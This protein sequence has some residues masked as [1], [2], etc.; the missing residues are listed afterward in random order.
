MKNKNL[1]ALVLAGVLLFSVF[2]TGCS[3]GSKATPEDPVLVEKNSIDAYENILSSFEVSGGNVKFPDNYGGA[4][5]N[6]ERRLVILIVPSGSFQ[7]AVSEFISSA[8][9]KDADDIIFQEA[10]YSLQYLND[11]MDQLNGLFLSNYSNPE[12]IWS[13]VPGFSLLENMNHI[14]IYINDI[15]DSKI[16]RFKTEV[17]D[18]EAIVFAS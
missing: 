8:K 7:T 12:S 9:I 13:E 3:G 17:Y 11:L 1:F 15:D 2:A 18:S 16:E 4:Y 5:L 6:E 14:S 10:R